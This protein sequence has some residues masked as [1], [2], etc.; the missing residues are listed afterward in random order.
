MTITAI[1]RNKQ[2]LPLVAGATKLEDLLR[3]VQ[4]PQII[5]NSYEAAMIGT[6][7]IQTGA[8]GVVCP[9]RLSRS[10]DYLIIVEEC[11]AVLFLLAF[12]FYF[13]YE[14]SSATF[15]DADFVY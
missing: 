6:L 13:F 4:N 5:K 7:H 14:I 8:R 3:N 1:P 15:D 9:R 10:P 11:Y 2:I 12:D